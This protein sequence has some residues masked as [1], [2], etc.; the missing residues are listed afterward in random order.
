MS[1]ERY[2]ALP[3]R[4]RAIMHDELLAICE[5]TPK[6]SEGNP[7]ADGEAPEGGGVPPRRM[8]K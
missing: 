5:E 8:R 1:W 4:R 6:E 2:L 7:G 3:L